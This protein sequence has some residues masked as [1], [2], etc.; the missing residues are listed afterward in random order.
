[1]LVVLVLS[2]VLMACVLLSG[3]A[4][5][6]I[7][8]T[9]VVFLVA[10]VV[11]GP[12]THLVD[13]APSDP[14]VTEIA[15]LA[16][17]AVLFT[18][19]MHLTSEE[20]RSA[21]RLPGRALLFGLPLSI[22]VG[23]VA[24]V[25]LAGTP[26]LEAL[27]V[28]AVLAPTDPVFAAAIVGRPE[29]PERLRHLLNVESGLN[30][31]LVLPVVIVLLELTAGGDVHLLPVLG[32]LALGAAFG[33]AVPVVVIAVERWR[34]FAIEGVYEPLNAVA[35]GG[36]LFSLGALTHA[37]V[38]IAA[39]IAGITVATRSPEV[40]ASFARFAEPAGELI[41]LGAV[42]M[43]GLLLSPSLFRDLGPGAWVLVVVYLFVVRTVSLAPVIAGSPLGRDEVL[44]ASWFGP[45]GFASVT[46]GL[47]VLPAAVPHPDL[48]FGIIAAVIGASI[49]LHSSTDVVIA[50]WFARRLE[51][52][53]G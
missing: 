1:M 35:I 14:V 10:G 25:L 52:E 6:S 5:R 4:H 30:D 22:A 34:L 29:V 16:L 42:F 32:E 43:F 45:K 51:P 12:V 49:V 15:R 40:A 47:L 7:L 19:G 38:Y 33:V 3:L 48:D 2:S 46:Y 37:N 8:S 31:G 9:T 26:W 13:L 53:T 11:A 24:T 18:D 21:W 23:A 17:F 50:K 36:V 28:A 44:A 39:F 27:L 20:L 41:K